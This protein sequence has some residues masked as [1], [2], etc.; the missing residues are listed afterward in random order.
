MKKLLFKMIR[1]FWLGLLG[2]L[3]TF[4]A[5][6]CWL[7]PRPRAVH[8]VTLPFDQSLIFQEGAQ[9]SGDH[10]TLA[11]SYHGGIDHSH[12]SSILVVYDLASGKELFREPVTIGQFVLD[13]GGGLHYL[14][15]EYRKFNSTLTHEKLI[16]C[17]PLTGKKETLAEVEIRGSDLEFRIFDLMHDTSHI[18]CRSALSPDGKWWIVPRFD[19]SALWYE[20]IDAR[21]GKGACKLQ[22]PAMKSSALFA[23]M[24]SMCFTREEDIVLVETDNAGPANKR[25]QLHWVDLKTGQ[26][27]HSVF[28]PNPVDHYCVAE[29]DLTV[30]QTSNN[31]PVQLPIVMAFHGVARELRTMTLEEVEKGKNK[32]LMWDGKPMPNPSWHL[33]TP[34]VDVSSQ[35]VVTGWQYCARLDD[36]VA[37]RSRTA[38]RFEWSPEYY[39]SSRDLRTG[40]LLRTET[41]RIR[42]DRNHFDR[43]EN[44]LDVR[45]ILPG[46]VYVLS[47]YIV[48]NEPEGLIEKSLSKL[49]G[50]LHLSSRPYSHRMHFI[51][52][53][54]GKT[55]STVQKEFGGSIELSPDGKTLSEHYYGDGIEMRLE[56]DYPLHPPWTYI[57]WWSLSV[58]GIISLCTEWVRWRG[59]RFAKSTGQTVSVS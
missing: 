21:T 9:Y 43:K 44:T 49:R 17:N 56:Y 35:T 31:D 59:R 11:I 23:Q 22:L 18:N 51:D 41:L 57:W 1:R 29:K 6:A 3:V 24:V 58:A 5:L 32:Q 48:E 14:A 33:A 42:S 46:P 36:D 52:A 13:E 53:L 10:R 20:R 38:P 7:Q 26:V 16:R 40:Q 37:I 27:L 47:H 25:Y 8:S 39:F 12:D 19:E 50:W 54:T 34:M 4:V 30:V 28:V 15:G 55:L 2:L 45:G